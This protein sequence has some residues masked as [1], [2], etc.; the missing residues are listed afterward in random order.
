ML[1]ERLMEDLKSAMKAKDRVRK[2]TVTML[3]AAIKQVEVDERKTLTDEEIQSIIQKQIREKTKAIADFEAGHRPDLIEEAQ[4]EI[5]I[6]KQ[7]LPEQMS[8]DEIK[9]VIDQVISTHGKQIGPVMKAMK[10][11][12]AAKAD[13]ALVNRLVREKLN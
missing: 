4:A 11:A 10:E 3:R 1:I 8:E 2:N 5:A 12:V 9:Q 13:M 6:L 7:Y